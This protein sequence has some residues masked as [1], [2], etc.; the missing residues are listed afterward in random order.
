MCTDLNIYHGDNNWDRYNQDLPSYST[1]DQYCGNNLN[2]A[3][4]HKSHRLGY[5]EV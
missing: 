5:V 2:A 3:R 1:H 4:R